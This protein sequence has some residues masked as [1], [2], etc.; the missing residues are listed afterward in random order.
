M[1]D[2]SLVTASLPARARSFLFLPA[3]RLQRL[4][5]ALDSGAHMVILD[6]EDAVAPAGKPAARDALAQAWPTLPV[7][8]RQRMLIRINACGTPWHEDDAALLREL[9]R[10]G[11][12]GAM[13]PKAESEA[14]LGKLFEQSGGAALLPLIESAEGLHAVDLIARAP[15]VVRLAFGHLD[16]QADLGLECGPDETELDSIRLTLVMAS[17]R[18]SLPPPVDGVTASLDDEKRLA[19]DVARS[20]RLGF[21]GKLCIHPRQVALVDEALGPTPAQRAWAQE[22]IDASRREGAGAFRLNGQMIDAPVLSRAQRLLD[23]DNRL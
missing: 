20:R 16:F 6:L 19:A 10:Y 5:K 22:V 18:A 21:A 13:P 14:A 15:G 7:E 17:R 23:V 1:N 9:G 12:G 3:D 2:A 8:Q 4:P 11:L